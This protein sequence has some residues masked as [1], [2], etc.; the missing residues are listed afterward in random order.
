VRAQEEEIS[1]LKRNLV[2]IVIGLILIVLV[3]ILW[4]VVMVRHLEGSFDEVQENDT[5]DLVLKRMGHPWKDEGC[6]KYLGGQ[7]AGCAEEFIYAHPYAPY[8][9]EYWVIDLNSSQ[10]VMNHAHLISP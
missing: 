2:L 4:P 8:V 6:G 10:R 1:Q 7:A 5:K 3:L 9:P